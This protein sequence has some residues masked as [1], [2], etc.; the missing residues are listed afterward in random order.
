MTDPYLF[1]LVAF[2]AGIAVGWLLATS[3]GKGVTSDFTSATATGSV[4]IGRTRAVKARVMEMQCACGTV[5]KFRD[6]VEPGY[7]PFPDG[8]SITCS[9][10]GRVTKL[11]QIRKVE[12]DALG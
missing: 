12:K 1:A 2:L 5:S 9:S 8:D 7:Q 10:C 4:G 11:Q 6:P 3:R